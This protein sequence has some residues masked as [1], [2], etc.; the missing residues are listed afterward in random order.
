MYINLVSL[1]SIPFSCMFTIAFATL[2][3]KRF[4]KTLKLLPKMIHRDLTKGI[5]SQLK[6]LLLTIKF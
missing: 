3:I 2:L 1:T 6:T 4:R 5:V